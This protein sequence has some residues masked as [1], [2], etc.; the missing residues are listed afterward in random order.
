MGYNQRM[1]WKRWIAILLAGMSASL[2]LWSLLPISAST[3]TIPINLE[4]AAA[5]GLPGQ[6]ILTWQERAR[7][8]EPAQVSL[9]LPALERGDLPATAQAEALLEL[10]EAEITPGFDL[11]QVVTP[12]RE[13]TFAWEVWGAREGE[14]N[15]RVWLFWTVTVDGKEERL[16]VLARPLALRVEAFLGLPGWATCLIA[17]VGLIGA[18]S[19]WW[20]KP[21]WGKKKRFKR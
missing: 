4:G 10:N 3:V 1:R 13:V 7:L 6:V 18:A 9:R 17:L 21:N 19:L 8:G 2:L 20:N 16:P 14:L 15:G 11:R 5:K 12:G